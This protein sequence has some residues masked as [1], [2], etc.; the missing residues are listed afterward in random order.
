[1]MFF[2][3]M[4][5]ALILLCIKHWLADFVLQ[6]QTMIQ[7]KGTYGDAAGI[8]HSMIHGALT[9]AVFVFIMPSAIFTAISIG[10]Y[11]MLIHYHID[12][13]KMQFKAEP[14]SSKFWALFGLDQL[15]HHLTYI[16]IV[17]WV[18]IINA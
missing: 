6:T 13:A 9:A 8:V 12:W 16:G 1:M 15:L 17:F 18:Y 7:G 14:N 11:D 10:I 5:G 4:F 2:Q 3:T